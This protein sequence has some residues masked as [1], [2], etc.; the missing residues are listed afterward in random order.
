MALESDFQS[1]YPIP[2]HAVPQTACHLEASFST[3]AI[4]LCALWISFT[5]PLFQIRN[6]N[7]SNEQAEVQLLAP[8][9]NMWGMFY[10]CKRP[11][12]NIVKYYEI[13]YIYNTHTHICVKDTYKAVWDSKTVLS[14]SN[15]G[16]TQTA[17]NAAQ[18]IRIILPVIHWL[19]RKKK[20]MHTL[21][22]RTK[23]TENKEQSKVS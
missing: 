19:D 7:Y 2:S 22:P 15:C 8:P 14:M 4:L 12:R 3:C 21:V 18:V 16:P 10:K 17:S 23:H 9:L 20:N 5:K 1:S 11:L 6:L 13:L